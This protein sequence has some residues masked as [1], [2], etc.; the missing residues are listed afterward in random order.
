MKLWAIIAVID[1][2][3]NTAL[4]PKLFGTKREAKEFAVTNKMTNYR[5]EQP[6]P[7]IIRHVGFREIADLKRK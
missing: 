3:G 1:A 2:D 6:P 4:I 5:I 7:E